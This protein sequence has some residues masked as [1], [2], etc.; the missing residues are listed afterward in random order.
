MSLNGDVT[1]TNFALFGQE[2]LWHDHWP[3]GHKWH[4]S[5]YYSILDLARIFG[6]LLTCTFI[7]IP[8]PYHLVL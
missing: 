1:D 5:C 8:I 6:T 3:L 4:V 7:S 2:S